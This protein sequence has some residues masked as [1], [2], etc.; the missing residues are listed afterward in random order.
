M[1]YLDYSRKEG[2][3]IPN[4]YGG[5]ENLEAVE[6]FRHLNHVIHT[7]HPGVATIAE[8]STAWPLVTRP[9][10]LGGLGFS[11][12]WNMGWMHD[13]LGYFKREAIFRKYHQNDLTFAMLYHYQENFVLPLSHD[14][15]VH[16]KS[17]LLGRMPGDV[18]QGF[19]NLRTLFGYQWTFPGKK[20][21][22]MGGEIGQ[23]SEWNAN[24][25]VDWGVVESSA[26]NCGM[27]QWIADLNRCYVTKAALHDADY[28]PNGFSW[29]D[30]S[31]HEQSVLVYLRRSRDGRSSL[32]IV[33]NLT[34][35]PRFGYRI[36][37]PPAGA[38]REVLNSDAAIYGGSNVGNCGRVESVAERSH[39]WEQSIMITLP[40]LS[41]VMF[42][43]E[44]IASQ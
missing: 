7:E 16:G 35:V 2:E 42:E 19:A 30:C 37:V 32:V 8:E 13:T 4:R 14:E 44:G 39:G 29:I 5:R 9:P 33:L 3:W 40:P 28:E 17:S 22:F 21:L 41:M 27:Q 26:L 10:Y 15:V 20:L 1:L 6:F 34:P 12:K 43:S 11:L 25:Q 36:G 24:A 18:W 31:D 23:R 38:W